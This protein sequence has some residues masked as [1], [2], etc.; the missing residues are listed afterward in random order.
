MTAYNEIFELAAIAT[1][2]IATVYLTLFMSA[3][4]KS[5]LRFSFPHRSQFTA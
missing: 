4:S 5:I 1:I 2:T 3:I